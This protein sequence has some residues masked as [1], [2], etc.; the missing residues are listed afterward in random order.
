MSHTDR[1]RTV[2]RILQPETGQLRWLK[3]SPN[4]DELCNSWPVSMVLILRSFWPRA[5]LESYIHEYY[6]KAFLF[7]D[8]FDEPVLQI[9]SPE[10]ELPTNLQS[11]GMIRVIERTR[12]SRTLRACDETCKALPTLSQAER[13]SYTHKDT[14]QAAEVVWLQ[15]VLNP[16]NSISFL[17]ISSRFFTPWSSQAPL[18]PLADNLEVW[19]GIPL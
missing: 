16:A 11:T 9:W 19:L 13:F 6:G 18:Q 8:A 4:F 1:L 12:D 17:W 3:F 5:N 10:F 14:L 7:G 15:C 2:C